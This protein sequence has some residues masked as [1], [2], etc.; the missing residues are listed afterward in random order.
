MNDTKCNGWSNKETWTIDLR[1]EAV[2]T[3]MAEEQEWDDV[4]HLADGFE[5]V[6]NELDYDTLDVKS[7]AKEVVGEYLERVDWVEI[8][9]KYFVGSISEEDKDKIEQIVDSLNNK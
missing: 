3:D 5:S 7:F 1:Y 4:H 6:V 8:A 9:E 2:F